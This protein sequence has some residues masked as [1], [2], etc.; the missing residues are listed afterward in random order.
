[1]N[2]NLNHLTVKRKGRTVISGLS[3][4]FVASSITLILGTN[5]SGKSTLLSTLAGDLEPAEGKISF[6]N[7]DRNKV[8]FAELARFRSYM[9]QRNDFALAFRVGELLQMVSRFSGR[10]NSV[11][12]IETTLSSLG[13]NHLISRSVFE[14][15]GGELQRLSLALAL[16]PKV[17]IYLLDEPL[18]AQD[19]THARLCINY[20]KTLAAEGCLFVIATQPN[21]ALKTLEVD[22]LV[23]DRA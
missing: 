12:P 5:G 2:L 19:P 21:E 20:F 8:P 15:S 3:H 16:T 6:G 7:T 13:I 1:M 11:R 10:I 23:L 22:E 4:N 14:L 18:S 9:Q 17:P